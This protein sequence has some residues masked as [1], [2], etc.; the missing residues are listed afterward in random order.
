M[1]NNQLILEEYKLCQDSVQTLESTIWTTS[2]VIGIGSLGSIV[3][4]LTQFSPATFF[5]RPEKVGAITPA[6]MLMIS[7]IGVVVTT[8]VFLWWGMAQR[9]WT[10]QHTTLRRMRHLE[11]RLGFNQK[12]YIDFRDY[13]LPENSWTAREYHN[14]QTQLRELRPIFDKEDIATLRNVF[15]KNSNKVQKKQLHFDEQKLYWDGNYVVEVYRKLRCQIGK[16][17]AT[18]P[19]LVDKFKSLKRVILARGVQ[20]YLK[21]LRWLVL[22]VWSIIIAALSWQRWWPQ[23]WWIIALI[24]AVVVSVCVCCGCHSKTA[25]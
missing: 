13:K 2:G 8:T 1:D 22:G 11:K 19:G 16:S 20:G 9:W 15:E 12:R 24:V 3:A 10:I 25:G 4:I 7:L 6:S 18:R 17:E 5:L 23:Q 14:L 21:W